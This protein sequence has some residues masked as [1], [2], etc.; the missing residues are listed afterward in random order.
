[1]IIYSSPEFY[2]RLGKVVQAF[3]QYKGF[4]RLFWN[5]VAAS[6]AGSEELLDIFAIS[7]NF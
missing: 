2:K 3:V 1:M 7:T 6:G 4:S 5:L